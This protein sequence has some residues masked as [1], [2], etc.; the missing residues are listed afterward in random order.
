MRPVAVLLLC[1]HLAGCTT[2][3][4]VQIS[5]REFIE[6]EDPYKIR[7]RDAIGEWIEVSN[8]RIEGDTIAGT[9]FGMRPNG[10]MGAVRF[11]V[12][13]ADISEIDARKINAP[14]TI[15]AVGVLS[16]VLIGAI[17]CASGITC[18]SGEQIN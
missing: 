11:R 2:W 17:L 7:F 16:A 5:P 9:T 14:Q 10:R 1:L 6:V 4:P 18:S 12:G 15:V 13:V 8:P 3:Q